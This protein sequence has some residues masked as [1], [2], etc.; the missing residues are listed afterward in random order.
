MEAFNDGSVSSGL[1]AAFAGSYSP[2][3]FTVTEPSRRCTYFFG[4]PK[5]RGGRAG[6]SALP[7]RSPPAARADARRD[8]RRI[9][10]NSI[11][12]EQK[13]TMSN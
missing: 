7:A 13:F 11:Y 4:P 12:N 5:V 10:K 8:T 2:T 9:A 6:A 3:G 1:P